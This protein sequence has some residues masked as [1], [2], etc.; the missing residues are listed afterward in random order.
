VTVFGPANPFKLIARLHV[1]KGLER[2]LIADG[3]RLL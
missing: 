3:K 2:R 1:A